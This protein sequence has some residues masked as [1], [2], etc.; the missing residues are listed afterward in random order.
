M[1]EAPVRS[2]FSIVASGEIG[3]IEVKKVKKVEA[4]IN[5]EERRKRRIRAVKLQ[6]VLLGEFRLLDCLQQALT[7]NY[8]LALSTMKAN[9]RFMNPHTP[10]ELVEQVGNMIYSCICP[11]V[12]AELMKA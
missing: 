7:G 1:R 2:F 5:P 10:P 8:E 9:R 4:R 3:L 6:L 11:H 12:E